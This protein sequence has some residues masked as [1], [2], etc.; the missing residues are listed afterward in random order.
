[1]GVKRKYNDVLFEFY[2]FTYLRK[3]IHCS[4]FKFRELSSRKMNRLGMLFGDY[5]DKVKRLT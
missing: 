1:M 5:D 2:T 4:S 3:Q